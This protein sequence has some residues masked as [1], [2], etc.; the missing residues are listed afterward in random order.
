M[1][2]IQ[3]IPKTSIVMTTG[4]MSGHHL[5]ETLWMSERPAIRRNAKTAIVCEHF[6]A[7]EWKDKLQSGKLVYGPTGQMEPMWT[8]G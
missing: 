4:H 7:M 5:D 6:G 8:M 1:P 2:D 3:R